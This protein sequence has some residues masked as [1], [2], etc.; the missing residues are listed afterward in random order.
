MALGRWAHP[1]GGRRRIASVAITGS[2]RND[3]PNISAAAGAR[4]NTPCSFYGRL[5]GKCSVSAKLLAGGPISSEDSGARGGGGGLW[6]VQS[7]LAGGD[8]V[9]IVTLQQA[10]EAELV[11]LHG[12]LRC[13]VH[14]WH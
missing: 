14:P 12:L 13:K 1:R 9:Q 6:G 7:P 2:S 3:L 10:L 4:T 5:N 8:G 11:S